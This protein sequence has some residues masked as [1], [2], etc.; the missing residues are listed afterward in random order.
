MKSAQDPHTPTEAGKNSPWR[1]N[2][3]KTGF[4][5]AHMCGPAQIPDLK[6][7]PLRAAIPTYER[8]LRHRI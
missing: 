6:T 5:R 3:E 4:V 7:A 8:G 2:I 1:T